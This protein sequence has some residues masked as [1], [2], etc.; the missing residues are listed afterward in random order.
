M[1]KTTIKQEASTLKSETRNTKGSPTAVRIA[2]QAKVILSHHCQ[3]EG[4][5]DQ[6][7]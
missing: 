1:M 4:A 3:R 2:Q 6:L 7:S 5:P